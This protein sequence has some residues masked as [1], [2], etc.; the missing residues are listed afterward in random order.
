MTNDQI[1]LIVVSSVS[2]L[3]TTIAAIS[4]ATSAYYSRKSLET[5]V[6]LYDQEQMEKLIQDLN[7][8]IE[9]GIQ[10]PYLESKPFTSKWVENMN[11]NDE[12]YLRYDMFCNLIFNY[13]SHV[14]NYFGKDKK[15]IEDFVDIK[16]WIRLHKYCWQ[17]PVDE[18]ENIDAYDDDFRRFINSY[19]HT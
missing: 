7:K 16:S 11:L 1:L 14:Y 6:K 2:A 8:I 9:I 3:G 19:I 15:Q 10:Y 4:A 12:R 18:N 13:L 5:T 17:K